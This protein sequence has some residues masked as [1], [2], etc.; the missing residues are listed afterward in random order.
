MH[1]IVNNEFAPIIEHASSNCE[2]NDCLI[3]NKYGMVTIF[4]EHVKLHNGQA[5]ENCE[6]TLPYDPIRI[7]CNI[8][9]VIVIVRTRGGSL[10]STRGKST[11]EGKVD[12]RGEGQPR[13]RGKSTW[14]EG[15]VHLRG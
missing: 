14:T 5:N 1:S 6:M 10:P 9:I 13:L 3:T 15:R 8:H 12:H 11:Y 4:V 7:K 2:Y